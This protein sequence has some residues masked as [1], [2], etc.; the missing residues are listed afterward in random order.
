MNTSY[1]CLDCLIDPSGCDENH[2][3]PS[4]AVGQHLPNCETVELK[5][6]EADL[7]DREII[8]RGE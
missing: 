8:E 7:L 6:T 3:D 4:P 5:A 2:D 1:G